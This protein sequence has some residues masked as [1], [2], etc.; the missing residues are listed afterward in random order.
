MLDPHALTACFSA[1]SSLLDFLFVCSFVFFFLKKKKSG[2]L[3]VRLWVLL[4]RQ[5]EGRPDGARSC[6]ARVASPRRKAHCAGVGLGGR[7]LGTASPSLFIQPEQTAPSAGCGEGGG[8]GELLG[9]AQGCAP[10]IPQRIKRFALW[11]YYLMV[12]PN[13][14]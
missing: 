13:L 5:G 4:R 9:S 6:G 7:G 12:P 3:G 11:P 1:L 8:S 2:F 10:F 14:T